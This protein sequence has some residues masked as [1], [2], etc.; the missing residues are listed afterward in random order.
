MSIYQ[1]G[2]NWYIDFHFHGQRIREMIGSRKDAE[3]VLAKRKTEINENKF[4][5]KRK[6][7]EAITFHEF[8]K[9]YLQW[10]KANH[11]PSS[12][13]QDLSKMRILDKTFGEKNLH[14]ITEWEIEK[15]KVK[16]KNYE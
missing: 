9:Q 16:R 3:K 1:R 10:V 4:L 12:L 15:W 11:K 2:K 14:E 5:D 7:P 8:A 13:P 6:D